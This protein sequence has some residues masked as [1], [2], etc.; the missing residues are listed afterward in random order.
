MMAKLAVA[1]AE[2]HVGRPAKDAGL[3]AAYAQVQS[4]NSSLLCLFAL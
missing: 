3:V 2:E 1:A 4:P